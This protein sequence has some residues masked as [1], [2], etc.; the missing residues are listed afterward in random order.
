MTDTPA[1]PKGK[2]LRQ[3][4][5][6]DLNAA[7]QERLPDD[8]SSGDRTMRIGRMSRDR[9]LSLLLTEDPGQDLEL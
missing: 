8:H 9:L 2:S 4:S 6:L 5:L 3:M 1:A 7:A